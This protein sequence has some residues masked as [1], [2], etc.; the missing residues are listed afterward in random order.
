MDDLE[1]SVSEDLGACTACT[2]GWVGRRLAYT[3]MVYT[4]MVY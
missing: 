3:S 4:R 2:D 1:S